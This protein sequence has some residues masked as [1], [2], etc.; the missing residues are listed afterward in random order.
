[1]LTALSLPYRLRNGFKHLVGSFLV[2]G[3][4]AAL[5]FGVWYP[6]PYRELSGGFHLFL[7]LFFVDVVLGPLATAIVSRPG[8]SRREWVV[9]LALIVL[10]QFAAMAYG[11]WTLYQA[12]PVYMVFEIDRFRVVSAV[13]VPEGW[14]SKAP[15]D[16]QQLPVTG[17][18][19]LA[20][21]PFVNANEQAEAIMAALGGVHLAYRPDFWVPYS[22]AVADVGRETKALK[23]S[24][25]KNEK[26]RRQLDE[27][28]KKSKL[29]WNRVGYI[30]L[31]ASHQIWTVLM[32]RE[33]NMPVDYLDM[34]PFEAN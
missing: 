28:I 2:A 12:R 13:D 18:G 32:D 26:I 19:I 20:V 25:K 22:R 11:V 7:I 29:D 9:D 31:Y 27:I 33:S 10:L 23:D 15:K 30:P 21:R 6:E 1:M 14:L 17:P 16:L 5:V 4:V 8:K 3:A 24:W 34:D